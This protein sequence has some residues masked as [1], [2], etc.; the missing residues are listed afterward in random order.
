M[1]DE[2][3]VTAGLSYVNTGVSMSF[4]G[5]DKVTIAANFALRSLITVTVAGMA[6]P[7]GGVT[8]PG[9]VLIKNTDTTNYVVVGNSGDTLPIQIKA[10][11]LALFR[12]AAGITPYVISN[13]GNV[14]IDYMLI[15][16]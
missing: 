5:T 3:T 10:G 13:G 14:V 15:S 4:T 6:L 9:Y 16:V 12:W 8:T 2:L 7:L 11:E 1:A